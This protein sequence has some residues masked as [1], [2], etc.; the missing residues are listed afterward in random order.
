M[1]Y[2]GSPDRIHWKDENGRYIDIDNT[3][4]ET[5]YF[6]NDLLYYHKNKS[7]DINMCFADS[8]AENEYP[9]RI[10]YQEYALSYSIEGSQMNYVPN[11]E[12]VF[13]EILSDN[14]FLDNAVMYQVD[15]GYDLV[16]I[17]KNSGE[18]EYIVINE[19]M[20]SYSF[21]F[22][23]QLEGLIPQQTEGGIILLNDY[24]ETIFDIGGLF[25]VDSNEI[26]C[27]EVEA[28]LLDFDGETA[29]IRIDA[30]QEWMNDEIRVFPIIIDP[31]TMVCGEYVTYD[32]YISSVDSNVHFYLY[33]YLRM[34]K[35]DDYGIRRTAIKF[36]LPHIAS[37]A[38]TSA[39][40]NVRLYSHEGSLS[41]LYGTPIT[42]SWTSSGITW[43]NQPSYNTSYKYSHAVADT[44]HD[45]SNWYSWP[46]TSL[47]K[48][49][50]EGTTKNNG[51]MLFDSVE[52]NTSHWTTFY[53]SDY[54][55]PN[56][57]EL[58][59]NYNSID[60]ARLMGVPYSVGS[61]DHSSYQAS[62]KT[63]LTGLGYS[64]LNN[65]TN[66]DTDLIDN[67]L[68]TYNVFVI[69]GHGQRGASGTSEFLIDETETPDLYY[70]SFDITGTE[71]F[72]NLRFAVFITCYGGLGSQSLVQKV[73]NQ[74]AQSV[75][76]SNTTIDCA[77]GT[78]WLENVFSRIYNGSS[79]YN[80]CMQESSR[81][82]STDPI[83]E[84]DFIYYA[85]GLSPGYI[86]FKGSHS[87]YL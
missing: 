46:V 86:V 65:C 66:F 56:R 50:L 29:I 52:N 61:H 45:T 5:Y 10:E 19:P 48:Q 16:Y 85:Y 23:L 77:K 59:V 25:A 80:A 38:V 30:N 76:G 73:Y 84:S 70:S 68:D 7:N 27:D 21:V 67:Y 36:E 72:S 83:S 41:T 11:E 81:S 75:V 2:I 24:G 37:L 6:V 17:P 9:I 34:G 63:K 26:Y 35:D 40:I 53:S 4:I 51:V 13:P 58:M 3:I 87:V 54:G 62:V 64:V 49:W 28:T 31:M 43:N 71:D 12:I 22:K 57:P 39:C 78:E 20:E 18:K 55:S 79:T 33:D 1:Q 8:S 82:N 47:T 44:W 32:S 42:S 15:E 60:T 69:K 14:V 74:G